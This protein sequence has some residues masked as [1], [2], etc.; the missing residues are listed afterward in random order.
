MWSKLNQRERMLLMVSSFLVFILLSVFLFRMIA[1]K[2]SELRLSLERSR[3]ELQTI[4]RLKDSIS[5]IPNVGTI[6]NRNQFLTLVT[7]KL[8]EL[9]LTP[10]NIRDREER[11]GKGNSNMIIIDLSF[12]GIDLQKL[13]QFVYEIEYNQKGIKIKELLIR[14]PLPGR[15]IFDV[16]MS[17]YVNTVE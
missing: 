7:Q 14:K 16:R 9:K 3:S 17:I 12:N 6:P 4:I 8:Q 5:S 13:F 10:N 1:K 2:R 11:I 15:D